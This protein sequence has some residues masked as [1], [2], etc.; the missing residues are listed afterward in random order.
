MKK[1]LLI[2]ILILS[3]SAS[4]FGAGSST[5]ANTKSN[6]DRAVKLIIEAKKY[7]N[8]GKIKKAN[9]R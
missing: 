2:V 5:D 7:E 1:I 3:F 9:K 8:K 6:Y 4:S